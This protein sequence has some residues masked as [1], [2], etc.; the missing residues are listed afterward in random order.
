MGIK[1]RREMDA[2]FVAERLR[3]IY[4]RQSEDFAQEVVEE[5]KKKPGFE[6]FHLTPVRVE[7]FKD[8]EIKPKVLESMR[9]KDVYVIQRFHD[10]PYGVNEDIW[11]LFLLN[12][13]VMRDSARSVT[14]VL[15]YL[16]YSRQ[17]KKVEGRVPISAKVLISFLEH[18]KIARIITMDLHAPAI[19]AFADIPIDNLEAR[20]IFLP[21]LQK[22]CT[23]ETVLVS[24]DL[25][26]AT[27]VQTYAKSLGINFSI[28]RK[29]REIYNRNIVELKEIEGEQNLRGKNMILIDDIVDTGGTI[30]SSYKLLRERGAANVMVICS[31]SLL[32]APAE[33][34]LKE[35]NCTIIGTNSIPHSHEF[36]ERNKKWFFMKNIA[37]YFAE[38]IYRIQMGRSLSEDKVLFPK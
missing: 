37:P 2:K 18:Q 9:Q 17:E 31:H 3:I 36:L 7:E 24:P 5:L 11:E 10:E 23:D 29:R 28:I 22:K 14:N 19:Q 32:S 1:R 8:G 38:A 30:V 15:P 21:Y 35:W 27:R 4:G 25:G 13:T 6:K 34:K 20:A 33:S 12:D 16:P 26:G